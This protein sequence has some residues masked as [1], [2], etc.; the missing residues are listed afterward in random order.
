MP[1]SVAQLFNNSSQGTAID[2]HEHSQRQRRDTIP[3]QANGL[4]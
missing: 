1:I 3:A 4:G 2:R